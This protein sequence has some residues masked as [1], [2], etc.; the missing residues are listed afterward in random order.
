MRSVMLALAC[1]AVMVSGA[2]AAEPNPFASELITPKGWERCAAEGGTCEPSWELSTSREII[3]PTGWTDTRT[4]TRAES[5][6]WSR[7]VCSELVVPA[8]WNRGAHTQAR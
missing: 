3:V 8:E 2:R 5:P 6:R 7:S 4:D 1:V